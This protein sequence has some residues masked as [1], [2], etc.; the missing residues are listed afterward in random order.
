MATSMITILKNTWTLVSTVSV[1]FQVIGKREV[2]AVEATSLPD[3]NPY[4]KII[5]PRRG[6]GFSRLD[7]NLYVYSV[8]VPANIAIDPVA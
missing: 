6:Y 8:D 1:S 2:Y 7:G 4:G 5:S 3:G